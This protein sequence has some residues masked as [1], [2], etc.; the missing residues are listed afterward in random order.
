MAS[1]AP[2]RFTS[3]LVPFVLQV[4]RARGVDVRPL[5]RKYLRGQS[6][7]EVSLPELAALLEDGARAAK[8]PRFGLHC[9]Q[10]MGRGSYGLLEFALRAAPT[11]RIAMEQLARYGRLINPLVRWSLE[12]DGDEV[13]LHHRAPRAGGVGR[14]GN[15]FTV[16]RIVQIA[17]EML[18]DEVHPTAA[19]FA[20]RE[21]QPEEEVLRFLGTASVAFGRASNGVSF[22]AA[23]LARAPRDADAELNRALEVHGVALLAQCADLDDA[24]ERAR[25]ALVQELP[26]GVASLAGVAKKLH[27]APRTLQRRLAEQGVTFAA[28]LSE[29][30]AAQAE[31]LLL[32]TDTPLQDVA[33]QLGYSDRAAFGRAFRGWTGTTPAQFRERA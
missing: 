8:D 33:R 15:L 24:Y 19:W 6:A 16:A 1:L 2:R 29:V 27:V 14:Q 10:A 3:A 11:A 5:E 20:H 17:R 31:R 28:L 13:S 23:L 7:A 4:L 25:A 12:V 32:R 26:R 18:G 21:R 22:P 9:A 30:R